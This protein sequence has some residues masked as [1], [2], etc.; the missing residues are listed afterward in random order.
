MSASFAAGFAG[1]GG[2]AKPVVAAS[3]AAPVDTMKFLRFMNIP[4][5]ACHRFSDHANSPKISET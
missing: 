4:S 3:P 2:A 1:A 5:F